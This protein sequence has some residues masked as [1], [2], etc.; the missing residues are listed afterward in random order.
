MKQNSKKNIIGYKN[1]FFDSIPVIFKNQ[2]LPKQSKKYFKISNKVK[3]K[4]RK[5]F[6]K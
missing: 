2:K 6:I 5:Y 3:R 4:T 1:N